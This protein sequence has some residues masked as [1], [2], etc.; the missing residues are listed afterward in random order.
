MSDASVVDAAILRL[1]NDV[2]IALGRCTF[3][4][5]HP[6]KRFVRQIQHVDATQMSEAQIDLMMLLAYRYRRQMPERLV[7]SDKIVK[8]AQENCDER[9]RLRLAARDA[10]RSARVRGHGGAA[11]LPLLDEG[12]RS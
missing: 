6:H 5:A 11:P 8:M 4:P 7:P 12:G 3:P 2:R 1:Q 9:R 10:K